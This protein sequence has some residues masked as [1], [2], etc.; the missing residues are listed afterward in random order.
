[1]AGCYRLNHDQR[2]LAC[3]PYADRVPSGDIPALCITEATSARASK[4]PGQE[5]TEAEPR[6]ITGRRRSAV[7]YDRAQAGAARHYLKLV[8][9]QL[10]PGSSSISAYP[11]APGAADI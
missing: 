10:V 2:L 5:M 9:W 3:S 6:L 4:C 1:M 11:A 7:E 8:R